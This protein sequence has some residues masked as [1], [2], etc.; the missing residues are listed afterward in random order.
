MTS[1]DHDLRQF[2]RLVDALEP[3]LDRVLFIGGWAH[4]LFRERPEAAR[5]SYPP[6]RT[7][8]VD[9]ALDP[10]ALE[11]DAGIRERLAASGFREEFLGDDRPP[12][13]HYAL[14]DEASG[15]Y[16][17]FLTPLRGGGRRRDGSRD[18][19][20]RVAGV[21]AQKLRYLDIL[22]VEPWTVTIGEAQ[23][24]P[25][26]RP[27]TMLIPN[28]ASFIVQKLLIEARRRREDRAKDVLYVHDTIELFA[29]TLEALHAFFSASIEPTLS[30]S[31]RVA[32]QGAAAAY[33]EVTDPIREAALIAGFRGLTPTVIQ[34][35]CQAGLHRLIN[36]G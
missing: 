4:R 29:P 17:E 28:P 2:A 8:D 6:L 5:L 7:G 24:V 20:Q 12:V 23:G 11:R 22:L 25:L 10:R 36:G 34:E 19:T 33:D 27:A 31:A 18:V 30:R 9:V 32:L 14:G 15:F 16:V 21:T 26:S 1:A 35:V 3:W 13:T